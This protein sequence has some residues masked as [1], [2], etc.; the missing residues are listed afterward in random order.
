MLKFATEIAKKSTFGVRFCVLRNL[1]CS[2]QKAKFVRSS[3]V[4]KTL[5][6]E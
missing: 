2:L 6:K 4:Q 5:V 3:S 1:S